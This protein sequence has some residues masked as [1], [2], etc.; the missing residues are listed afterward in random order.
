MFIKIG[1]SVLKLKD[2]AS[3]KQPPETQDFSRL[4]EGIGYY[5]YEY[6][7]YQVA[8]NSTSDPYQVAINSTSDPLCN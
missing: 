2:L 4:N 3:S 1:Q 5:Y 6:G 8:I 7:S